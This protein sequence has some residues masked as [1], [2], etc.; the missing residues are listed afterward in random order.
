GPVR[1]DRRLVQRVGAKAEPPVL[2]R[3][4]LHR[5][6]IMLLRRAVRAL[7]PDYALTDGFPVPR[8][9]CPALSIKK[10]DMLSAS[11]AAASIVAK[12]TRDRIMV[13][14]DRR[15]PAFGFCDN[16]GYGTRAHW[17]ALE[18]HGPTPV[19]RLSFSGVGQVTLPGLGGADVAVT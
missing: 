10:G 19:H 13:R 5:S 14:L 8:M 1:A 2:D 12:V 3:R 9:P 6:N 11:V 18:A 17:V 4:G 16:K 7:D 15:Y